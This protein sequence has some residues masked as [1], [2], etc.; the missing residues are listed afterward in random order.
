MSSPGYCEGVLHHPLLVGNEGLVDELLVLVPEDGGVGVALT[1]SY[2][3]VSSHRK[4]K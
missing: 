2:T 1:H 3:T 4:G